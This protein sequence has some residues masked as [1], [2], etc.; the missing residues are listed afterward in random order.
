MSVSASVRRLT[1]VAAVAAATVG[2][3]ALPVAAAGHPVARPHGTV[4][5]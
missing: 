2:A 5:L 1:A 3:L 4:Y